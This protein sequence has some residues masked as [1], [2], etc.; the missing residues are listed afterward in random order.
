MN[1]RIKILNGEIRKQGWDGLWIC[2]PPNRRYLSGFTGSSGW[3]LATPAGRATL[4][5]DGRYQEQA[6]QECPGIRVVICRQAPEKCL[7]EELSRLGVKK[8]GFEDRHTSVHEWKRISKL[9]PKIRLKRG[10][11]L[12][13]KMRVVKTPEE[14]GYLR[15]AIQI[16]EKA[17]QEFFPHIRAGAREQ[18]LAFGLEKAMQEHGGA[19]LAFP[20]IVASGTRSALP[21]AQPTEKKLKKGD[22]VVFDFGCTWNGYHSDLTRTVVIGSIKEKQRRLY[23]IVKNAQKLSQKLLFSGSLASDSD[24]KSREI[25]NLNKI[26]KYFIH[27]LGHGI[28]LEIHEAP[29]L[30]ILSKER[31]QNGMVATCEPGIYF[32]GWGGIRIEDDCLVGEHSPQWLSQSPEELPVAG[33]NRPWPG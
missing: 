28:G 23:K 27:S 18:E 25:F 15:R 11:G 21:H 1:S 14:I 33:L 9:V 20:T 4:I 6:R 30:S 17:F 3:L 24:K 12:V 19:G 32:P 13:E 26:D 22:L 10:S 2:N 5:T 16:A 7:A 29:R 8:L 31:L